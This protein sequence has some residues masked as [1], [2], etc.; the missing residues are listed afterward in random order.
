M[1]NYLINTY[2]FYA[3]GA[4]CK[5]QS[6]QKHILYTVTSPYSLQ[7]FFCGYLKVDFFLTL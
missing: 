2:K 7:F 1:Y 3:F 5:K 4:C 6:P